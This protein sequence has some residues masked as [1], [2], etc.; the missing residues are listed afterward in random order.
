MT[1]PIIKG[2]PNYLNVSLM[3]FWKDYL[4]GSVGRFVFVVDFQDLWSLSQTNLKQDI[5]KSS[6]V[7]ARGIPPVV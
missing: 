1:L 3:T 6:C 7:N 4:G 2:K 5:R